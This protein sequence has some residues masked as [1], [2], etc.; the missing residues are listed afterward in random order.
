VFSPQYSFE[1]QV[2]VLLEFN[3]M[4]EPVEIS[5]PWKVLFYLDTH[6]ERRIL[7]DGAVIYRRPIP[8]RSMLY[9]TPALVAA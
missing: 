8:D 1:Q 9:R 4:D 7:N 3:A 2:R 6:A 5:V